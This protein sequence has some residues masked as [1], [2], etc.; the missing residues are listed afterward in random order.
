M[1]A[2]E[3]GIMQRGISELDDI[4]RRIVA[5]LAE[6]ADLTNKALSSRLGL[7][8]STCAYR[9]RALRERGVIRGARVEIDHAALGYPLQAVIHVRLAGHTQDGVGSL[10][11]ALVRTPR[12]LQV[13]H[14][15]GEDDFLVHVAVA[16]AE[17]LR[18]IVLQHITVHDVV[19]STETHLVFERRDGIAQTAPLA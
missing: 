9:V 17:A 10:Y 3:L 11:A 18:D 2:R 15:A 6:R 1:S 19:R 7:A 5:A 16:D 8:E 14:V 4:D 13:F 12:V